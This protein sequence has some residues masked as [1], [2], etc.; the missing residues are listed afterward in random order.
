MIKYKKFNLLLVV[1]ANIYRKDIK[2][3]FVAGYWVCLNLQFELQKKLMSY[4]Q[5]LNL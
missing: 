3:L 2:Q 5:E 4:D 1:A